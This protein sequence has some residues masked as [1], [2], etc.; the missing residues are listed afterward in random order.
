MKNPVKMALQ[1]RNIKEYLYKKYSF[2]IRDI[3]I[4]TVNTDF[5]DKKIT[6]KLIQNNNGMVW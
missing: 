5:F 1:I 3:E 6:I 2:K 4:G